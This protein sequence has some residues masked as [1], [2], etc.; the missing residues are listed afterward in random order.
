MIRVPV[1]AKPMIMIYFTT[2]DR[3]V[4]KLNREALK[5]IGTNY[6]YHVKFG[7]SKNRIYFDKARR[8]EKQIAWKVCQNGS[9]GYMCVSGKEDAHK[10]FSELIKS[11]NYG[12]YYM[13]HDSVREMWYIDLNKRCYE[14]LRRK[15]MRYS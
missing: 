10:E 4:I 15:N 5:K 9:N 1:D 7:I 11:G 12:Y 13:Y 3:I 14:N 8:D 6:G 2:Q